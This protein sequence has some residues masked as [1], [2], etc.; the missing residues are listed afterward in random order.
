MTAWRVKDETVNPAGVVPQIWAAINLAAGVW[1][2]HG[3]PEL[4]V[5]GL[6]DGR[7]RT[8]SLHYAG[9]A[10]DLR[11]KSLPTAE[12]KRAAVSELSQRL[13][14]HF[15]VVLE[16]LDGRNEHAH[17]EFQPRRPTA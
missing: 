13:G 11:T 7:H 10:A 14:R 12:A 8:T 15:D 2:T 5:T 3:A 1:T 16:D 9:A 6:N 17:V 4:V